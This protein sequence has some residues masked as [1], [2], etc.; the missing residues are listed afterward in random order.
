VLAKSLLG[1]ALTPKELTMA[2]PVSTVLD[3]I[4]VSE[5]KMLIYFSAFPV[6]FGFLLQYTKS[7]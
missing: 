5:P 4:S 2:L 7:T 6:F 1:I 3:A